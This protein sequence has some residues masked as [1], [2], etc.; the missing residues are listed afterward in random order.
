MK[1]IAKTTQNINKGGAKRRLYLFGFYV[2]NKTF[3]AIAFSNRFRNIQG[4]HVTS[5]TQCDRLPKAFLL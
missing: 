5:E 3:V 2:L 4:N 1:E